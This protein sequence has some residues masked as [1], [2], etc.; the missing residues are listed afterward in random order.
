MNVG[1]VGI[2]PYRGS[3]QNMVFL[4]KIFESEGHKT[5][6]LKCSGSVPICYNK[7][8]KNSTSYAVCFKCKLGSI[9]SFPVKNI[10]IIDPQEKFNLSL[11]DLEEIV[12]STAYSLHRIELSDDCKSE[13]VTLTKDSLKESA[14]IVYANSIKW[15][16]DN[17]IDLVFIF[18]GRLDL[19]RAVLK[20][21]E[22]IKVPFFTFESAY[23]GVALE[24]NDDCRSYKSLHNISAIYSERPLTEFQ[25]RFAGK[26]AAQMM[27]KS[28]LV[29]RLYNTNPEKGYW[30][31]KTNAQKVLIVPSSTHEVM[32]CDSWAPD[33]GHFTE[34]L[35]YVVERLGINYRDCLIRCHPNWAERIGSSPDGS[36]S[37]SHYTSWAKKR[38]VTIIPS[39]SKANT[40]DLIDEADL[41]LVQYG[42]AGLE[43]ALMGKRVIALSPS[44]YSNS[45][46][47][48]QIH[49][50]EQLI[51][52]ESLDSHD[53][54]DVKRKAL[55]YLY[56]YHKRFS[57]FT[58]NIRPESVFENKY[59]SGGS[60]AKIFQALIQNSLV[61]DD[62]YYSN[63][64]IYEDIALKRLSEREYSALLD[65]AVPEPETMEIKIERRIGLRWIDDIRRNFKGGDR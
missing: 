60:T 14:R 31:S 12:G 47:S 56:T 23:P 13:E 9:S 57:Q 2:Y 41:V 39:S 58:D 59:Y 42:T 63:T 16:R 45:G 38:G 44:F 36:K 49:K 50:K 65:W 7:L 4:S 64:T 46:F 26:I 48:V 54:E 62:E 55:R 1:F 32:G 19:P 21:C 43:A 27:T 10:S 15:I 6:F 40:N 35:E 30:P 5:F 29:W 37:E 34:G 33:W 22:S 20:A 8:I 61:A 3:I 17:K 18:N 52:L 28:N 24:V 11:D 51:N 53:P 25:A